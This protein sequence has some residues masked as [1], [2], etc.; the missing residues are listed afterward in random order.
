M[1]L[2]SKN[3][4]VGRC[5]VE[6]AVTLPDKPVSMSDQSYSR[7]FVKLDS[8]DVIAIDAP[9]PLVSSD[10]QLSAMLRD[11]EHERTFQPVIGR[12]VKDLLL[13]DEFC[14][15]CIVV[16]SGEV[17]A[18]VPGLLWIAPFLHKRG[19]FPF[20]TAKSIWQDEMA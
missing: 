10:A 9:D 1:K 16:D 12:T 13:S 5:I 2:L 19:D 14:G 11:T 18:S 6:V 8:G 20:P 4:V 15:I 17:I 7:G 3:D